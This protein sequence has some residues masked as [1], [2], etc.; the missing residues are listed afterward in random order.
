[1]NTLRHL[2]SFHPDKLLTTGPDASLEPELETGEIQG[3]ILPGFGTR[4]LLL[5]G[6]RFGPGDSGKA[7]GRRW[8]RE[9]APRVTTLSQV[10]TLREVRRSVARA[11]GRRPDQADVLINVALAATALAPLGL[12]SDRIREGP[13]TGGMA[14]TLGD[15]VDENGV[16]VGWEI[17][18][19]PENSPDILLMV[20][21]DSDEELSSS[22]ELLVASLE[23]AEFQVVYREAGH[24]LEGNKEHFGF[25]DDISHPGVRGR[26]SARADHVLT[27]RYLDAADPRAATF[28]RPGQPLI[29]PGQFLLGYATQS[30]DDPTLPGEKALPPHDWM[31]NGSYLVFR[32]LRQKVAAF[33]QF[34]AAQAPRV[35]AALGR[36][37]TPEEVQAWIVGRWPDGT[38]L[39]RSPLGPD[40]AVSGDDMQVNFFGIHQEEPDAIV[41]KDGITRSVPGAPADDHGLRCPHFAHTRKVNQRDKGTDRGPS[42]LFR[43]LRRGIPYGPEYQE[44]EAPETDRGLL[45]LAYHRSP[46][47]QFLTL[48][49][50]WMN[51]PDAPEGFGHD[52]LVGQS[53]GERF[54]R[55]F[56]ADREAELRSTAGE[57]WVIPTGGG[58]FFSPG[59]SVLANL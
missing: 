53:A 44:G 8:L 46:K 40:G 11:T 23:A 2:D 14:G 20:G 19:R 17:G 43:L 24:G 39:T 52:L 59:V 50:L 54:A 13:F 34:A 10:N 47:Q 26:L 32:R 15:P 9:L 25:R 51:A 6:V 35:S 58:F 22:G 16:P 30:R 7:A 48:N 3:N 1:M 57:A 45:F 4:R 55:R 33:R 41:T 29:W 21:S 36:T 37:I 12:P 31:M 42:A 56:E 38:P 18:S 5:L 49:N 27:R 28:A